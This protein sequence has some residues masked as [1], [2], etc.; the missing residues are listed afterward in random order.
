[1][2][3]VLPFGGPANSLLG[4]SE[5]L[6]MEMIPEIILLL[7]QTDGVTTDEEERYL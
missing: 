7:L 3:P 4:S 5:T 1:M 2:L 6:L